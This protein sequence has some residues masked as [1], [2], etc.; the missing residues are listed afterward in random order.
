MWPSPFVSF[1]LP[2]DPRR[3]S[4]LA[5]RRFP[6]PRRIAGEPQTIQA[7]TAFLRSSLPLALYSDDGNRNGNP[8][9]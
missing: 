4:A 3:V 6:R 7:S 8:R 9:S 1:C 2:P 5:A